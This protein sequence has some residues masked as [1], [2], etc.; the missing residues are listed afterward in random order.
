MQVH[1]S[2][3]GAILRRTLSTVTIKA[4]NTPFFLPFPVHLHGISEAAWEKAI[5]NASVHPAVFGDV[6]A[7]QSL[8]S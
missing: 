8:A 3:L 6:I 4:K 5:F 2:R 7:F 1:L